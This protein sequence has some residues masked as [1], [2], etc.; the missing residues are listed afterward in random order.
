MSLAK[1]ALMA[2]AMRANGVTPEMI[3]GVDT[4]SGPDQTAQWPQQPKA[5]DAK[6][7]AKIKAARKQRKGK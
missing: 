1:I 4:A 3:V 2:M 5:P 7:R 6:K